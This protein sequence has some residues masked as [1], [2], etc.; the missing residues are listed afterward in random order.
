MLLWAAS[1]GE[2][3]IWA[4]A[5]KDTMVPITSQQQ[6]SAADGDTPKAEGIAK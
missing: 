6:T 2:R 4:Q 5:F 3:S 1:Q